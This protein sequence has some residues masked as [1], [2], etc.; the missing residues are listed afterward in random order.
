MGVDD[1]PE[2][3][4]ARLVRHRDSL[5][6]AALAQPEVKA[7]P[8]AAGVGSQGALTRPASSAAPGPSWGAIAPPVR[9]VAVPAPGWQYATTRR[10]RSEWLSRSA[11]W[12]T[13]S[14]QLLATLGCVLAV[15]IVEQLGT[16]VG[17]GI[18][19]AMAVLGALGAARRIP[20]SVW[21]TVG[22]VVGGAL[23]RWS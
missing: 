5:Q 1:S 15:V 19:V 9:P 6:R 7:M 12:T 22:V 14:G 20:L 3:I 11:V 17:F 8:H 13:L 18:V 4:L 10:R 23:G 2:Q 16:T 21:W